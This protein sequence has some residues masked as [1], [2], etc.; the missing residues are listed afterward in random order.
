MSVLLHSVPPTLHR[1]MPLLETP[2]HSQASL[3]QSP[4]G[5]L[6]L[7]PGCWC[8]QGSVCALQ[9]PIFQSCVS[10][11][12]SMV[13][14]VVTSSKKAYAIPKS[15]APRARV[16]VAVHCWPVPPQ[17]M[18]K[19]SSVSLSVGSLGPGVHKIVWALWVSL[20]GMGFDSKC[21]FTPPTVLLCLLL[22]PWREGISSQLLQRLWPSHPTAGH[23]HHTL[24]YDPDWIRAK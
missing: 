21:E 4:V 13:G 14:L 7:I 18:L 9:E 10:S 24:I 6:L 23:T 2:G 12:S 3:G 11:G 16:P 22:C 15:A 17:E 20:A 1:P 8:T 5:S 19:Y